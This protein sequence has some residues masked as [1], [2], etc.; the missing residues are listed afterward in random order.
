MSI[1]FFIFDLK[2]VCQEYIEYQHR[3]YIAQHEHHDSRHYRITSAVVGEFVF[4]EPFLHEPHD[5]DT[6]EHRAK[7]HENIGCE[8]VEQSEEIHTEKS[9]ESDRAQHNGDPGCHKRRGGALVTL[10]VEMAAK[11]RPHPTIAGRFIYSVD[12]SRDEERKTGNGQSVKVIDEKAVSQVGERKT[13]PFVTNGITTAGE[14]VISSQTE[15]CEFFEKRFVVSNQ[16]IEGAIEYQ[17][18][19]GVRPISQGEFVSFAVERTGVRIG[20]LNVMA[21]GR[22]TLNLRAEY[23]FTWNDDPVKINYI[24]DGEVYEQTFSSL[25]S[26]YDRIVLNGESIHLEVTE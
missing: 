7:R 20:S 14:I 12:A 11:F 2:Q 17:S 21:D 18:G 25:K 3:R 8:I 16:L 26:L 6:G 4:H 9:K 10:S 5:K 19:S 22:F 1:L 23:S 13:L 24:K 15:I